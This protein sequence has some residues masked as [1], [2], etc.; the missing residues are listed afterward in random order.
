LTFGCTD[1]GTLFSTLAVLCALFLDRA[2]QHLEEECRR[3]R[4]LSAILFLDL[5]GFKTVNDALGHEVGDQ[6]LAEAGRRLA[7]SV[8]PSDTVARLGG[9]EFIVLLKDIGT[10]SAA[11]RVAKQIHRV[12]ARP[13]RLAGR[14]VAVTAS[15][16]VAF[17]VS[18]H[19][20]TPVPWL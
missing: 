17:N 1:F 8:R 15:I 6:L 14:S 10:P 16:G 12:L 11:L 13:F 19:E 3:D 4:I 20:S 7:N 9:D 2:H 18:A 5:D